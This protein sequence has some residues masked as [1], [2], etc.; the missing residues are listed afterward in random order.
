MIPISSKCYLKLNF[1]YHEFLVTVFLV[2]V[3]AIDDHSFKRNGM[4][5]CRAVLYL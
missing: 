3:L 2:I 1:W 4:I 5:A